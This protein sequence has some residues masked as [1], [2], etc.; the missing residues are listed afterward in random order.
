MHTRKVCLCFSHVNVNRGSILSVYCSI[1]IFITSDSVLYHAVPPKSA[2]KKKFKHLKSENENCL[3]IFTLLFGKI[4]NHI[5][6]YHCKQSPSPKCNLL[7][8]PLY[9]LSK[10]C[11]QDGEWGCIK[12]VFV[13]D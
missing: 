12:G 3:Q 10:N 13:N 5:T 2:K 4:S 11:I 9:S 7:F 1:S 6:P 8:L